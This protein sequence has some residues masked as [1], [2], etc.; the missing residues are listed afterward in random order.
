MNL[1]RRPF[2]FRQ[3]N[4]TFFLIGIN[5]FVFLI[6]Q[7][8]KRNYVDVYLGL[9]VLGIQEGFFWQ[10]VS[11]MFAHGSIS[12]I[13]FNMLALFIFGNA[14]EHHIGSWEFLVYYMVTGILAGAFSVLIYWLTGSYGVLLIGASGAIFAI[15]LAYATFFPNATLYVWGLI[16]LRAPVMVLVFTGIALFNTILGSRDGVAHLTHLAGFAFGWLY[17]LIRFGFNPINSLFRRRR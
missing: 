8:F 5:I 4:I 14:L 9:S 7:F 1:I 10:F 15:E 16:P 2:Q 13:I 12:H 17:F 3:Y 11:Y 6:Q